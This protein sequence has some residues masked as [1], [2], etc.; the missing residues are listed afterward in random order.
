[1]LFRSHESEKADW[2]GHAAG[3]LKKNYREEG[4]DK[5]AASRRIAIDEAYMLARDAEK[6]GY[7]DSFGAEAIDTLLKRMEDDRD[8]L[9][10]IAAGY[11]APMETFIRTNPG[12]ESR[13][14]ERENH[15][16]DL[17]QN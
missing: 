7:A 4:I 8:R 10:V 6:Y 11:P 16:F 17:R 3:R 12:L 14:T 2:E 1:M 15:I 13:F 5:P 9:V